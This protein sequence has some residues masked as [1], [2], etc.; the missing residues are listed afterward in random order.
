MY[1][2]LTMYPAISGLAPA[3]GWDVPYGETADG[4]PYIGAHRN[5]PRHLFA[6]GLGADSVTGAFLAA[7]IL[8]RHLA[9]APDKL[10]AVFGWTR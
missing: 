6:L 2:V 8:V 10:D 1:E 9:A 3:Y 5:F 4:L 7:R